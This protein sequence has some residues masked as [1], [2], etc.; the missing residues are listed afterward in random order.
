EN[1][2]LM[3]D[4]IHPDDKTMAAAHRL[5]E[6]QKIPGDLEYRIVLPD[7]SIRWLGHVC[8]PVF[9]DKG[10]YL[11][12]RASNR[13]ITNRKELEE[14]IARL[15]MEYEALMRHEVKNLFLP[16]RNNTEIL[17][18]SGEPL[19][20]N[21][22]ESIKRIH[23][24]TGDA[25]NFIDNLQKLQDIESGS[26]T[27]QK[28]NYPLKDL[29][30]QELHHVRPYAEQNAVT[31]EFESSE[32]NSN[33]PLDMSLMPGVFSNLLRNAIGQIAGLEPA[34]E[35][36]VR[37]EIHNAD[38]SIVVKINSRGTILPPER[39]ATFFDRFNANREIRPDGAGLGTTY[40][41]LVTKA[42]GGDI[43]ID[44]NSREGTTIT[45]VFPVKPLII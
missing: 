41:F 44:S 19:P 22:K 27:L 14:N 7:E 4:I 31:L 37:V 17:L 25:I 45:L 15:R 8:Q 9:D 24:S 43:S 6:H 34:S 38:S 12:T 3:I 2:D 23:E 30:Q 32:T 18:G 26:Y 36:R 13:D 11:G 29:I 42:H 16:I 39:T 21:L 20:V 10:K 28:I 5:E 1:P 40:A 33:L 35:R